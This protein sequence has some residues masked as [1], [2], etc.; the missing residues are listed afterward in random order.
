MRVILPCDPEAYDFKVLNRMLDKVKSRV[1][2]GRNAAFLGSIMLHTKFMWS[3]SVQTAATDGEYMWWNPADFLH[4]SEESRLATL[5]HEL[6]HIARLH[7]SR[8]AGL[9]PDRWN[10]AVD[11]KVNLDCKDEGF[12]FTAETPVLLDEK[13]RGM[14]EEHI[15]KLL[16][17]DPPNG[18]GGGRNPG[19]ALNGDLLPSPSPEAKMANINTVTAAIQAAVMAGQPGNVPGDIKELLSNFLKPVVHWEVELKEW[20]RN[21]VRS[22]RSYARPNRRHI[23]RGMYLP[24]PKVERK[25]LDHIV[26][27]EDVSCSITK[28]QAHRF[29]SECAH[30]WNILKPKKMTLVQFDTKIQKVDVLKRGEPFNEIEIHGRGGTSLVCVRDWIIENKPTA[31]VI[32]S[33]MYVAPM[34]RLP[35]KI[36]LLYVAIDNPKAVITEGRLIHIKE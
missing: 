1:F 33:D 34:E 26:F 22:G 16:P 3:D 13:Y 36:P 19:N 24:A 35:I 20:F 31:A 11:Y 27:F 5:V 4:C 17:P 9:Q 7:P 15:Y 30:V 8:G 21:L 28:D 18:G 10:R 29:N 6:W 2:L 12:N 23:G 32:F 25:N 14:L